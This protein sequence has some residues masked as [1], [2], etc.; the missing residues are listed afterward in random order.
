[1]YSVYCPHSKSHLC[2]PFGD[3]WEQCKNR[4]LKPNK[5]ALTVPMTIRAWALSDVSMYQFCKCHIHP[6]S[7]AR[8]GTLWLPENDMVSWHSGHSDYILLSFQGL[9]SVEKQEPLTASD[10]QCWQMWTE[11]GRRKIN[12]GCDLIHG[13]PLFNNWPVDSWPIQSNARETW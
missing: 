13:H 9:I 4:L 8:T 1:M 11:T 7:A 2:I 6:E 5:K 10:L 12:P 3:S